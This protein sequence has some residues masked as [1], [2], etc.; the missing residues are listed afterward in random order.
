[1]GEGIDA[2]R[3]KSCRKMPAPLEDCGSA[4]ASVQ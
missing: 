4:S 3:I 1:M 2:V